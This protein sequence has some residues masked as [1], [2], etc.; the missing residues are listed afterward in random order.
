VSAAICLAAFVVVATQAPGESHPVAVAI[1]CVAAA[2]S[3]F[4]ILLLLGLSLPHRDG[5]PS[6]PS[7]AKS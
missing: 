4:G 6:S 3:T 7:D 2:V 5:R 1:A